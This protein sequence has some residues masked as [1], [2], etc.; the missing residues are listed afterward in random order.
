MPGNVSS[1][2]ISG[3]LMAAPITEERV[4]IVLTSELE[5]SPY[6]DLTISVM[7]NYGIK[8]IRTE[9][10]FIV[11]EGQQYVNGDIVLEGDYSQAA[12]W[13]VMNELGADIL[14]KGL[15]ENSRQ[16]DKKIA[17][18]IA[19]LKEPGDKTVDAA[20]IPDL[21]PVI[22]VLA[23]VRE[24]TTDIINAER[25]KLKESDRLKNTSELINSIGGNAEILE[26]GLKIIGVSS[27]NGGS[28]NTYCDHRIAMAAAVASVKCLEPIRLNDSDCVRK[29]Y[30]E[31]FNEFVRLGGKVKR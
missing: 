24:G 17:E 9:T 12:F 5:S 22:A 29:S 21:V 19:Y 3:M 27:Y 25:L 2:F 14:V 13:M 16:G 6:V 10:G 11:E 23:G 30:P 20:N 28:V 18:I 4:E 7:E 1:Q 31:F 15:S 8:V 26:N